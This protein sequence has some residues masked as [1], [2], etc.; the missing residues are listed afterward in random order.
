M[1]TRAFERGLQPRA[2]HGRTVRELGRLWVIGVAMLSAA[3]VGAAEYYVSTTGND[4]NPGT[5]NAP[6]KT[7]NLAVGK[8]QPSDTVYLR[9]GT[10]FESVKVHVSGTKDAPITIRSYPGEM[11]TIDSGV[12]DFRQ[13][14]N[15]DW[16]LIDESLGEYRSVRT[17]PAANH[18][19]AYIDGIPG[20]ENQ[21][22]LLVPYKDPQPFRASS[23]TYVEPTTSFYIGPGVYY[24]PSDGRIHIRLSKTADLKGAEARYGPVFNADRPDPRNYAILL[25]MARHTLDVAGSYLTFKDLTINQANRSVGISASVHDLQF[26]GLT[27]WNGAKGIVA[28]ADNVS[29]VSITRSKIYGDNPYWIFWSDIKDE[30]YPAQLM[31]VTSLDLRGGA[32][33]WEISYNHIRGSGQDLVSTNTNE[34]RIFVHHNR[35]ENCADDAFEIEGTINVG[36]ISIHDNYISNCLTAAAPGQDTPKFNG[37]L[38]FYRNV[39]S[40]LRNPPIN[41]AIG[42]NSWNGGSRFGFM[43]MF[44]NSDSSRYSTRNA[45]FYHNTLILLGSSKGR[46][47]NITPKHPE[48]GRIANNILITI[49]GPVM[50]KYRLGEG[51]V[52]DGNLYWKLNTVDS[53]SLAWKFNTVRQLYQAKG[54][55]AQGIGDTPHRGTDPRL[56]GLVFDFLDKG[57]SVWQ[58]T[59]GSEIRRITDFALCAG[60]PAIGAGI[61]IPLHPVLGKLPDSHSS[62]DIGAI[63][64]GTPAAEYNAFP[65]VVDAP[66]QPP[67]GRVGGCGSTSLRAQ[68]AASLGRPE[69]RMHVK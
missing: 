12:P 47:I 55:E 15:G 49:N 33:D 42:I 41:R 24:E 6:F 26:D 54:I 19:Y 1:F 21:R 8:L 62:R 9:G 36:L 22:V 51:Q 3:P 40:L 5:L 52:V 63:P 2:R 27:I 45:H 38:L 31:R 20:Y 28:D 7:I 56:T 67:S 11:A 17:F 35:L 65:F 59:P 44:K 39:A 14:G 46:G 32:H 69:L 4:S 66:S 10:Y 58:L 30:P 16:E 53:E 57:N 64:F 34:D 50:D 18:P 29:N 68:D 60:S 37:P 25:S 43:E 23:E 13:V 61:D 48:D